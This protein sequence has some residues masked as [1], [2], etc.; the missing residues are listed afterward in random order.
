MIKKYGDAQPINIVYNPNEVV[1][2][3]A[4][5]RSH[6]IIKFQEENE[7]KNQSKTEK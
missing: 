3:N 7:K 4:D 2:K 5:D 6:E 1:K